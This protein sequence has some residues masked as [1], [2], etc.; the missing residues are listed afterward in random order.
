MNNFFKLLKIEAKVSF[1]GIDG[2][3]FGIVMPVGIASLIGMISGSKK[4]IAENLPE[5]ITVGI[6]ATAFMGILLG[7]ADYRDKKILKYYF[8]TPISPV[9]ILLVQVV[10]NMVTAIISSLAVFISMNLFFWYKFVGNAIGFLGAYFPMLFL[11]ESTIPFT[12]LPDPL[13]QFTNLPPL[14]QGINL[15]NGFAL[16]AN[17]INLIIPFSYDYTNNNYS[18]FINQII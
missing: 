4:F 18:Y 13:N 12:I 3:F 6:C 14:T 10:I 5:L 11:S 9:K 8:V 17:D 15:L 1:R 7:I 16:G 2:V